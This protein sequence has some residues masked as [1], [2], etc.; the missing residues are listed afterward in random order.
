MPSTARSSLRFALRT[1]SGAP[2]ISS[3]LRNRTGPIVG[4]IFRAMQAS[5][6]FMYGFGTMPC[7][8]SGDSL[9]P[10]P[11]HW[12]LR[13]TAA[14]RLRLDRLSPY[15]SKRDFVVVRLGWGRGFGWWCGW[16]CRRTRSFVASFGGPS[17]GSTRPAAEKLHRLANDAQFRSLLA[18]LLIVPGVKLQTPLN[19]N[20]PTFFQIF[21]GDLGETRP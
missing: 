3:S 9:R 8:G 19:K 4:S 18:A 12:R 13:S 11:D 1:R 14:S 2:K 10:L 7:L 6:E 21:T 15:Q 16:P 20:W 17:C 5:A